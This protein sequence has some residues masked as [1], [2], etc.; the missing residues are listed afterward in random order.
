MKTN[1]LIPKISHQKMKAKRTILTTFLM[2]FLAFIKILQTVFTGP[3]PGDTFFVI[4]LGSL[5]IWN[6]SS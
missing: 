6:E 2:N 1:S 4:W 5:V 3:N